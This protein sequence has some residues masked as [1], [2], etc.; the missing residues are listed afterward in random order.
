MSRS[1]IVPESSPNETLSKKNSLRDRN[2]KIGYV[3]YEK[4]LIARKVFAISII[5]S[6]S[7]AAFLFYAN[8]GWL[9]VSIFVIVPAIIMIVWIVYRSSIK[10]YKIYKKYYRERL[11]QRKR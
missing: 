2:F 11:K 8:M 6:L 7:F 9:Y 5:L 1:K 4:Y 10:G 3:L